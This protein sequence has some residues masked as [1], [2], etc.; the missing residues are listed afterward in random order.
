[1][2]TLLNRCQDLLETTRRVDFLGPLALRL[3]LVPV[4]WVA[5]MNKFG[6]FEDTVSWF[7]NA[8][9]GLGLPLPWLMVSLVIFAE[10]FGAILLLLGLAVRWIALPLMVTMVVAA[11]TV[12]WDNGWQAVHDPMSPFASRYTLSLEGDEAAEA[13]RRQE[14]A[15]ALLREHGN[16]RWLTE[17]GNFVVSN[18]G[19][20]WAATYFVMV[21]ALFFSGGG[22][23]SMDHWLARR[24]RR[25]QALDTP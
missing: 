6:S 7:G 13:G 12:H 15:R 8:Q 2:R 23:A 17:K 10:A 16:Y 5:G 20:E 18:N 1:M 9:W 4:F 24:Y 11:V 14:A 22:R 25:A 3:Y 21:L 19:I